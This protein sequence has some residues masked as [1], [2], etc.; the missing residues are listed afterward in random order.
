MNL[1][2]AVTI[3]PTEQ[4]PV[5][6]ISAVRYKTIHVVL[7][8]VH[9]VAENPIVLILLRKELKSCKDSK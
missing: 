3:S 5:T 6:Y 7:L 1:C 2:N 8:C 9:K 4:A